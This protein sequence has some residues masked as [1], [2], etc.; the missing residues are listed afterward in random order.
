M[1]KRPFTEEHKKK[2]GDANRGRPLP[3]WH[4]EK[5]RL[6]HLGLKQSEETVAKRRGLT[7][8]NK[9]KRTPTEHRKHWFESN[10]C[11]PNGIERYLRDL[12]NEIYP[13]EYKYVG[14]GQFIIDG[15]CPDF[16]NI[17]GKKKVIN[18][19]GDFW[20]RN[21][22]VNKEISRYKEFG[23]DCLILWEHE[24]KE[25]EQ[26]IDK[27]K[28]F[29]SGL[30]VI[31]EQSKFPQNY[32]PKG[33]KCGTPKGRN[34]S[35]IHKKQISKGMKGHPISEETKKKISASLKGHKVD[36]E[37]RHKI[38]EANLGKE[39]WNKGISPT[40]ETRQK[41]AQS[42]MGNTPWNK[43]TKGLQVAWNKGLKLNPVKR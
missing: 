40:P 35:D 31:I 43:G 7:P 36:S 2:I 5:L 6:A 14:D 33:R 41:I 9:G 11:K 13:N 21:D 25:K 26:V 34:L 39:S 30:P 15:K 38:S 32:I 17:N 16:V 22:D 28:S 27:V 19:N 37:T 24:L 1:N 20:H 42:L 18:I 23:F 12:L 8:W 3:L 29:H 4:K 10:K